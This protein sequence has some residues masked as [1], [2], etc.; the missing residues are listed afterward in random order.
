MSAEKK[1]RWKRVANTCMQLKGKNTCSKT[2]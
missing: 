1:Y 2:G